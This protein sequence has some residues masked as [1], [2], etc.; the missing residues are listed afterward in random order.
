M[1]RKKGKKAFC[2]NTGETHPRRNPAGASSMTVADH[3]A[4]PVSNVG[5]RNVATCP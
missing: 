1:A 3:Q 4:L 5:F 2:T